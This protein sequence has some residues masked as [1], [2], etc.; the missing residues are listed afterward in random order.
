MERCLGCFWDV[1]GDILKSGLETRPVA[2]EGGTLR[3]SRSYQ[4][5]ARPKSDLS[6]SHGSYMAP[7]EDECLVCLAPALP[8]IGS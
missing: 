8:A 7:F 5:Y 6:G 4:A 3:H 1:D 2:N